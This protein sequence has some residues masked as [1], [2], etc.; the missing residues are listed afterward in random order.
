[1]I[2]NRKFFLPVLFCLLC[3]VLFLAPA[4]G[5][6]HKKLPLHKGI[7][8]AGL[9]L[10]SKG[11]KPL[12]R[13]GEVI[14]KFRRNVS[15]VAI[16]S[17]VF[18]RSISIAK[19]FR[20]LS[21]KTGHKYMLLRSKIK[22]TEEMLEQLGK[23]PGVE[24]AEPNYIWKIQAVPNDPEYAAGNMWGLARIS[25]PAAWD[26]ATGSNTVVI[27]DLDTGVDYSHPDL[28]ANMW[29]NTGEIPGNG[30]DDDGDGYVDD[31]YGW[32]ATTCAKF[33]TSG[34]C[35]TPKPADGNPMD[36]NGHGTHTAGTIGAAGNNATGIT[37]VNWDVNIMAVKFLGPDGSGTTADEL[38]AIQYILDMKNRGVN[39][40]AINAS[41]GGPEFSRFQKDAIKMA[42]DAGILFVTAAG[43]DGTDNEVTPEYPCDHDLPNIICVA[44]TDQSDNLT[45]F[46]NF[47]AGSVDLAAPGEGILSSIPSALAEKTAGLHY[48][49]AV[50]NY[51]LV[52][53][54]FG[55]EGIN[56]VATRQSVMQEALAFFGNPSTI[57]LV[58]DD[59]T[60][61]YGTDYTSFYTQALTANGKTYTTVTVGNSDFSSYP[62]S[63][64]CRDFPASLYPLSDHDLVIWF[65][66][67][68]FL[69][70]LTA[71]DQDAIK[72]YLDGGGKLL[73]T[74]QD[75][76]YDL[77]E[78][79]SLGAADSG[80]FYS[81]Y[82]K[83]SYVADSQLA[84]LFN[85]DGTVFSGRI[86]ISSSGDGA[87]NQ[88][89]I[90]EIS[91]VSPA[92]S[93]FTGD[94]YSYFNGTS[95]AAPHVAGAVGLISARYPSEGLSC[96]LNRVLSGVDPVT[97]LNGKVA[98]GG[99]LNLYN[100]LASGA[101]LQ[102]QITAIPASVPFGSLNT[103]G[104]ASRTIT[105][106]NSGNAGPL[107][108]AS[109]AVSGAGS[110]DFSV[111]PDTC[112][113]L[114]P[115][116][117]ACGSC[118]VTVTFSP[119]SPGSKSAILAISS[120]DPANPV[121]D[122][123]LTGSVPG[124][125]PGY[126]TS[127]GGGGCFIATAA[128][129]SYMA[130][131]VMVLRRF[132]DRDLLTNAPG[133]LFVKLYYRYSPPIADY[134]AKHDSLR[135]MTRL[136]LT[137]LVYSVKYPFGALFVLMF[138]GALIIRRRVREVD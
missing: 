121:I 65:T 40:V 107:N 109:I 88:S 5:M 22:T 130:D 75:I 60:G 54:S 87:G 6:Y 53:F 10:S 127:G 9:L 17:G 23:D 47:G 81:G 46:S 128:Y 99:R 100:S 73:I 24:Y 58:D 41:Y 1:M 11:I 63:V 92:S 61:N 74:G 125:P 111:S 70:T 55:F 136:A 115:A 14:V 33:D 138:G 113:G 51:K 108:I 45:S 39:I 132:R 91:L 80:S 135:F 114:T 76:G 32:D 48:T 57:L 35:V 77:V 134:I 96:R 30:I 112:P 86:D 21:E 95:M 133:R 16:K 124:S 104:S 103:G 26:T 50:K 31:I 97:A 18:A 67:D 84:N 83:A 27:A 15:P 12:Y 101:I 78:D 42:G 69:C 89:F 20:F 82:L 117:S 43:N 120:D 66:G 68:D 110:S 7:A 4:Y 72:T 93:A 122:V 3:L 56:G 129:G 126:G 106:M 102:K 8:K 62:A 64:S 29:V 38:A 119:S 2:L 13:S 116:I 36:D 105:V 49:D 79:P 98:T 123:S 19:E 71:S 59:E 25:A 37:G 34:Q 137:P 28:T 94:I 90:D 118:S 44:A 85:G 131:D 52:Y